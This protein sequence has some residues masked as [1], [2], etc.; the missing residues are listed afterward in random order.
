V[1][2]RV[3]DY[4]RYRCF[5]GFETSFDAFENNVSIDDMVRCVRAALL[6]AQVLL[7]ARLGYNVVT[8]LKE[9]KV[10]L[11]NV[12]G[13]PAMGVD[14]DAFVARY[15]DRDG[16]VITAW[17]RY[18]TPYIALP[19]DVDAAREI[20]GML[21]VRDHGV[22]TVDGNDVV[23]TLSCV[24]VERPTRINIPEDMVV[25][26]LEVPPDAGTIERAF[27]F[28]GM[29]CAGSYRDDVG[30]VGVGYWV[31]EFT[32]L[33]EPGVHGA[34]IWLYVNDVRGGASRWC[35]RGACV[36][37]DPDTKAYVWSI[38]ADD[39]SMYAYLLQQ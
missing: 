9:L 24:D 1:V 23:V 2:R 8:K 16:N 6:A 27:V 3:S 12:Y 34:G 28:R 4:I 38:N 14:M 13:V 15:V 25:E 22:L 31:G 17:D 30:P 36:T 29:M 37:K 19:E 21:V 35:V 7:P 20:H 18:D 5:N 11:G 39:W 33:G 10:G 32:L 26:Q